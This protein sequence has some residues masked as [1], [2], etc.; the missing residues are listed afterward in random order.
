[1][2]NPYQP[3]E[4]LPRPASRLRRL[5]WWLVGLGIVAPLVGFLVTI[6]GMVQT[7]Q[8]MAET[9]DVR[10]ADLAGGISDSISMGVL[11]SIL[12]WGVA[13]VLIPAGIILLVVG[14]KRARREE[15]LASS[16]LDG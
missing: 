6:F 11:A 14:A 5:G 3:P 2:T 7:F 1:M 16:R 4:P 13:A 9:S 12:G 8:A 10:T 15:L